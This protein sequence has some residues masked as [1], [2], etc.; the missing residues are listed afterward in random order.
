MKIL[1]KLMFIYLWYRKKKK[2]KTPTHNIINN[3]H[4]IFF[5]EKFALH[6]DGSSNNFT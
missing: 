4:C 6:N 1:C 5:V 3:Q 2:K